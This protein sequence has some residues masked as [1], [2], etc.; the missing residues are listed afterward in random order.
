MEASIPVI[1]LLSP[2]SA[3]AIADACGSH[4]FFKAV[5]HGM[6]VGIV[7]TLEAEAR[8]FFALPEGDKLSSSADLSKPLGYGCRSIGTNGDVGSVEYLLM[9]TVNSNSTMP[10]A[11]CN[12]LDEYMRIVQEVAGRVLVLMAEGLGMVDTN[13]FRGMVQ[14]NDSDELLRVNHYPHSL[15]L[16]APGSTGFGEH[17]DPQLMSLLRSNSVSGLQ[18]ALLDGTWL[19][20]A[21]DAE[22]IFI[23]VGDVMQVLTNGR[24]RSV[25]HRV[26][27]QAGEGV[28][29]RLSMVYFGGPAPTEWIVPM[30]NLLQPQDTIFYKGFWWGDYKTA[31]SRTK[32][33]ACRLE[34]FLL[35]Q[36]A[37][38]ETPQSATVLLLNT[39]TT[40]PE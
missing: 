17:T 35:H 40:T 23:N 18:I 31:A 7:E 2:G 5:N 9:S 26:V 1:D 4:G 16:E 29:S 13:V 32:L 25:R 27:A 30:P 20:V 15:R 3:G 22:S 14:R 33:A 28:L 8:S 34:P 38:R 37:A 24:Y 36:L 6:D 11:L 39:T 10:I 12:A 19:P 21:P